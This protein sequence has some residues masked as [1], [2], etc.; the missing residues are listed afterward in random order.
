M[1]CLV[2]RRWNRGRRERMKTGSTSHQGVIKYILKRFQQLELYSPEFY[3]RIS[4][5]T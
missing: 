1:H 3:F 4:V 5:N 2:I